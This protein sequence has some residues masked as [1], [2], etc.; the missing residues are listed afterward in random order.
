MLV[1]WDDGRTTSILEMNMVSKVFRHGQYAKNTDILNLRIGDK[2]KAYCPKEK[3]SFDGVIHKFGTENSLMR[4]DSDLKNDAI[5]KHDERLGGDNFAYQQIEKKY[6][7]AMRKIGKL[8]ALNKAL[9]DESEQLQQDKEFLQ[10]FMVVAGNVKSKRENYGKMDLDVLL[11]ELV[12]LL[13]LL[14]FRL[15]LNP[16]YSLSYC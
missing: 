3:E 6:A 14:T 4:V 2:V 10:N 1:I 13:F 7:E 12:F 5:A 16:L 11:F 15:E 8:E 9:A